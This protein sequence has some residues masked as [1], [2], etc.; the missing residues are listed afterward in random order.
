MK[1]RGYL[2]NSFFLL[3]IFGISACTYHKA[4]LTPLQV[5]SSGF[6]DDVG[7]IFIQRCATSGCH[8]TSSK[9][10]AADLDLSAWDK[11]YSGTR[12]GTAV[13]PF[14]SD[15]SFLVNFVNTFADLGP[16]QLPVMPYDPENPGGKDLL[17]RDEVVLL[18]NWIDAGA[19]NR[20]GE[21][22]FPDIPGRKKFYVV[23]QACDIVAVFDAQSRVIMKYVDVGFNPSAIE[24]PHMVRISPDKK[25]WFVCFLGS[26]KFQRF[27]TL[28]DSQ[29][30]EV[31]IGIGSWNTFVFSDDSKF[32]FVV[33]FS[34]AGKVA[35]VNIE[36]MTLVSTITDVIFTTPHGI[37]ITPDQS[38]LYVTNNGGN[39]FYKINLL[40]NPPEMIERPIPGSTDAK[41][42]E[43]WFSPDGSKFFMTCQGTNDVKI[44]N[45]LNDQLI[46]SIPVL[47]YPSEFAYSA[48]TGLLFISCQSGNGVS[49]IDVNQ[50][51]H[52]KDIVNG[53]NGLPAFAEPH[54]IAVDDASGLVFVASRNIPGLSPGATPPHHTTN[55]GGQNG[56]ISAINI[57][58]LEVSTE[59]KKHEVSADPYSL[60]FRY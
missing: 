33:D 10:G 8:T 55:C 47:A 57:A 23:N 37:A 12:G 34:A 35:V 16:Q 24:S 13:V 50:L 18:K 49:V 38:M 19:R 28:D 46:T 9:A 25:Y 51:T 3:L 21:L 11:M 30:G 14:R 32:A 48:A 26:T 7:K 15:Q 39:N 42:H 52:V 36:T 58:T 27:K 44:F 41:P 54:G 40:Q 45:A 60:N 4:D 2:I 6:P 5:A 31:E 56:F 29:A 59:F 1:Q 17:T 22:K 20:N 53:A 43:V